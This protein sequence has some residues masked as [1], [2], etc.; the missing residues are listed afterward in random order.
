MTITQ[1]KNL[2]VAFTLFLLI[3]SESLHKL[4]PLLEQL[5]F[6]PPLPPSAP[7][8]TLSSGLSI[9]EILDMSSRSPFL[10]PKSR[11][12]ATPSY[13]C[14]ILCVMEVNHIASRLKLGCLGSSPRALS[15][16]WLCELGSMPQI[17]HL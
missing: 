12:D 7:Q 16:F 6:L 2:D 15:L 1:V 11:V 17:P 5:P 3:I 14:T 13:T 9:D 4:F 10:T 8:L